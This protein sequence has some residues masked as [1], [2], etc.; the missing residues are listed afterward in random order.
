MTGRRATAL[1]LLVAA[2]A[3]VAT[4]E[5][6]GAGSTTEVSSPTELWEQFPL[7]PK[8]QAAA[9]RP[10]STTPTPPPVPAAATSGGVDPFVWMIGGL[11]LVGAPLV[12]L[13]GRLR[14]R[15]APRGPTMATQTGTLVP[16]AP[17]FRPQQPQPQPEPE[18]A[19]EPE[20]EPEPIVPVPAPILPP[21]E[22]E[23]PRAPEAPASTYEIVWYRIGERLVFGLLP[24]DGRAIS[25]A[26]ARSTSFRWD[27]DDDPP[28]SLRDAQRAHG[29]LR[30]R[31]LRD[32]WTAAGRGT[33]WFS[34]R[35]GPPE[36]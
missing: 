26:R 35:F 5:A 3:G 31:L 13:G 15:V 25:E 20:P 32:G 36:R 17:A 8:P 6:T 34:H 28:A 21:P 16:L 1:V 29:R 12:L 4:S 19:P 30:S 18:P 14:H 7:D 27:E 33:P 23:P 22:Q 9:S 10:A 24:L 2:L 11:L